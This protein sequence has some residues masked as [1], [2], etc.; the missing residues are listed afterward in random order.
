MQYPVQP[1]LKTALLM[2]L[3]VTTLTSLTAKEPID[4]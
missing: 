3:L 2:T 1:T 4:Y